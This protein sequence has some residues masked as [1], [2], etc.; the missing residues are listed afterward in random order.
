MHELGITQNVVAIIAEH[1]KGRA[2]S[3]V[4]L[5][6]GSFSGVMPDALEF[7]FDVAAKGTPL[8]GAVLEIRRIEARA[9]CRACGAEFTQS[10]LF[11]P[12]RCGSHAVERLSGEELK[13]KEYE[14]AP[15]P[16][17]AQEKRPRTALH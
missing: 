7:C 17:P 1:A 16:D 14:L 2:V 3:R 4:V 5:E 8:D 15:E 12:C 10:T 13:I 9:H 11:S 6:I